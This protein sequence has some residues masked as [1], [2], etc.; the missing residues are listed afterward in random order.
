MSKS[1]KSAAAGASLSSDVPF[2]QALEKLEEIVEF[3]QN[4]HEIKG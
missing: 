1:S 4:V 3:T 2:E